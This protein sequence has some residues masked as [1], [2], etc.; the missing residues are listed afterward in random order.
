MDEKEIL[1][2]SY[3]PKGS[4]GQHLRKLMDGGGADY[5]QALELASI[6][7]HRW[8]ILRCSAMTGRNLKEGLAW[9][10]D[11]AKSRLFLY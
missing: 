9:V 3:P 7:T 8:H 2:V 4:Y 6:R 5:W 11:D 1:S 10:V